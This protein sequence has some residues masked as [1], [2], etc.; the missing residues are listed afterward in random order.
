[1]MFLRFLFPSL[2]ALSAFAQRSAPIVSPEVHPDRTVTFRIRA[3]KASDVTLTGDWLTWRRYDKSFN[4]RLS[5]TLGSY[6]QT[7]ELQQDGVWGKQVYGWNTF[8]DGRYEHEWKW[9]PDVSARYAIGTR[10]FPYDGK[11][12][13]KRYVYLQINWRF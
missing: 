11:Y 7:S 13:T 8:Q 10:R 3:P 4:Q 12:E 2:L 1:M 6:R 9:G 5:F